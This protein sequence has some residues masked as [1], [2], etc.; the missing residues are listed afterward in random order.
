MNSYIQS[1][2]WEWIADSTNLVKE[3][4]AYKKDLYGEKY[5]LLGLE[6]Y[7]GGRY[8]DVLQFALD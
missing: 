5:N 6:Y 1:K 3:Y 2:G 7:Y 4:Y 8:A